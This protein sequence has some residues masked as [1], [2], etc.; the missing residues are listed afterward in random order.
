MVV[1]EMS[2]LK[3]EMIRSPRYTYWTDKVKTPLRKG[4]LGI[5]GNNKFLWY[6][7]LPLSLWRIYRSASRF[8]EPTK[9]NTKTNLARVMLDIWAKFFELNDNPK[10]IPFWMALKKVTV[11]VA[12]SDNHYEQ[13]I[14]WFLKELVV[15]YMDGRLEPLPD[16]APMERWKDPDAQAARNKIIE[17]TFLEMGRKADAERLTLKGTT[18]VPSGW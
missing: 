10:D 4:L 8:L 14:L 6:L 16:W 18:K 5:T 15:A 3:R 11:G 12:E 2:D 13:R 1:S 7:L 9:E 17:E